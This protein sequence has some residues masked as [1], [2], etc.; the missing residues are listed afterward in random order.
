MLAYLAAGN[1]DLVLLLWLLY[2]RVVMMVEWDGVQYVTEGK[3]FPLLCW[4]SFG[5][6]GC[7]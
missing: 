1:W 3:S 7:A 6:E 5:F 2:F 4:L